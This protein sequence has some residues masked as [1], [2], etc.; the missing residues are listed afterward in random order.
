MDSIELTKQDDSIIV[1]GTYN[2]M[3]KYDLLA[4]FKEFKSKKWN[5]TTKTWSFL[6]SDFDKL[7]KLFDEVKLQVKINENTQTDNEYVWLTYLVTGKLS[8]KIDQH[9]ET[10][11]KIKN[12]LKQNFDDY[13]FNEKTMTY[14]F[15][16]SNEDEIVALLKKHSLHI[17]KRYEYDVELKECNN[18]IEITLHQ[19]Q[20]QFAD[21]LVK[22]DGYKWNVKSKSHS[23]PL[24]SK[25]D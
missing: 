14:V 4:K 18:K 3:Q 13:N 25:T 15:D 21:A 11:Y 19:F 24:S 1:S 2:T 7:L 9:V 5:K 12:T 16:L 8:I 23:I 20:T 22:L 17:I 6:S 10:K